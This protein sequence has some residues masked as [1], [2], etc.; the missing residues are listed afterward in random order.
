[1][2]NQSNISK[3]NSNV[4]FKILFVQ[5][6]KKNSTEEELETRAFYTA[7]SSYGSMDYLTR[8]NA[9][10]EGAGEDDDDYNLEVSAKETDFES[11]NPDNYSRI[12]D[13]KAKKYKSVDDYFTRTEAIDK[14]KTEDNS[15]AFNFN[16]LI[17][18]EGLED[19]KDN[20]RK[21]KGN[22]W[23][24][25]FSLDSFLNEELKSQ[26]DAIVFINKTFKKFLEKAGFDLD[27]INMFAALHK[28]TDNRHIHFQFWEKEPK[29]VNKYGKLSYRYKGTIPE[30]TINKFKEEA[31][32]YIT[33]YKEMYYS[34]RDKIKEMYEEIITPTYIKENK[35]LEASFKELSTILPLT[36]RME[37]RSK[38]IAPF[39]N[40]I[41]AFSVLMINTSPKLLKEN[42]NIL[43]NLIYKDAELKKQNPNST[44]IATLKEDYQARIGNFVLKLVKKTRESTL[45][46]N[47]ESK[48]TTT[49]KDNDNP[50]DKKDNTIKK[51]ARNSRTARTDVLAEA[52]QILYIE[53]PY[54]RT[55]FEKSF[56]QIEFEILQKNSNEAYKN[57]SY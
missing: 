19:L 8:T 14:E 45:A 46:K 24:S 30:K 5:P 38:N 25:V 31:D 42:N 13:N 23:Y 39:V 7:N 16:G 36:G 26:E 1:M 53:L 3:V 54:L 50:I 11:N 43:Q 17:T 21:C 52:K 22:I 12:Y 29:I 15:G 56:E 55:N 18:K 57:N 28:N 4:F 6:N 51:Q 10:I 41:D 2:D 20:L 49:K 32:L 9:F 33:S 40:Q 37:Y 34:S 48:S 35:E 47:K 27:N 44:Y